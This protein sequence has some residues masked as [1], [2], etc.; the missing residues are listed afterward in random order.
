MAHVCKNACST[1]SKRSRIKC[2]VVRNILENTLKTS[3]KLALFV[4]FCGGIVAKRRWQQVMVPF[5]LC[6]KIRRKWRCSNALSSSSMVVFHQRKWQQFVAIFFFFGGVEVKKAIVAYV[7][8]FFSVLEK[9]KMTAMCHCFLLW[10]CCKEEG[11]DDK[12]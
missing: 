6:L 2:I 9:K 12:L 7:V 4:F 3:L 5:S 1:L 11:D 10:C 8:A